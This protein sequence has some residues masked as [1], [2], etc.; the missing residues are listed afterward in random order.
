MG[1]TCPKCER[2]L[3]DGGSG[4]VYKGYDEQLERQVA[5][6]VPRWTRIASAEETGRYLAEA[7]M[8]AQLDHPGIVPMYDVGRTTRGVYYLVSK[9]VEGSDLAARIKR[10]RLP[11]AE[12]AR[13]V[14]CA[15]SIAPSPASSTGF[16]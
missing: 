4:V 16:A 14:A 1:W 12:A 3:G 13:I 15:S 9:Y 10:E 11:Y 5:I 8:V 6:K 7:R 2:P